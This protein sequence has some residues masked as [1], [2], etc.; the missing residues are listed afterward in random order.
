MKANHVSQVLVI[1]D[2]FIQLPP[3]GLRTTLEKINQAKIRTNM[4][5]IEHNKDKQEIKAHVKDDFF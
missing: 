2:C 4:K 5:L 1:C 3:Q